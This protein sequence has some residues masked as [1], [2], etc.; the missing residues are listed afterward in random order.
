M[1]NQED[2][3][4]FLNKS[5]K[6]PYINNTTVSTGIPKKLA[7]FASVDEDVE[8]VLK[9]FYNEENNPAIQ[10]VN[11]ELYN[12]EI[13][14]EGGDNVKNMMHK[15]IFLTKMLLHRISRKKLRKFLEY[16]DSSSKHKINEEGNIIE[17]E[18]VVFR[19]FK[20]VVK[21]ILKEV[22]EINA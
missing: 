3:L 8:I 6:K 19:D 7:D 9:P 18:N 16:I 10:I 13:N 22:D 4:S 5:I 15:W 21:K 11:K 20:D 12:G 17:K 2:V 14:E 1:S